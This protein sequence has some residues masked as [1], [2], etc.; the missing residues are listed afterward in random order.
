MF[1]SIDIETTG[2]NPETC[3]ILEFAAVVADKTFHCYVLHPQMRGEPYAFSMHSKILRRIAKKTSDFNY[4]R[5]SDVA[6]EF[7][8]FL[9]NIRMPITVAGKNFSGFDAR[10]LD[11]LPRWKEMIKIRHRV[12]DPGN[13]Y[14][15]PEIDGD[16]LPNLE[17][18]CERAG[19]PNIITHTALEDAQIVQK[20]IK[21]WKDEV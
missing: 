13:L 7:Q 21:R 19:L 1:V 10:F 17:K 2:L 5:P 16:N 3:Q 12:L 20:L 8:M 4:L 14:W 11:K 6:I 9:G 18:C 15:K